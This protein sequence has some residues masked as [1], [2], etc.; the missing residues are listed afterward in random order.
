MRCSWNAVSLPVEIRLF[1]PPS[2]LPGCSFLPSLL[3]QIALLCKWPFS[4]CLQVESPAGGSLPHHLVS[5]GEGGKPVSSSTVP[6]ALPATD[7]QWGGRNSPCWMYVAPKIPKKA[8][9]DSSWWEYHGVKHCVSP[10]DIVIFLFWISGFSF[11]SSWEK[12]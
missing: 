11:A 9:K 12:K 6:E 1:P 7:G 2:L 8:P 3:S 4:I 5:G 10:F